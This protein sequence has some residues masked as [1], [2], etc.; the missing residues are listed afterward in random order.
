MCMNSHMHITPVRV[1]VHI[2]PAHVSSIG[3]V[4]YEVCVGACASQRCYKRITL[5]KYILIIDASSNSQK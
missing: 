4:V 1:F 5:Y 2:M 3:T